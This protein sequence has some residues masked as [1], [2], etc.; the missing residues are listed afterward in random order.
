MAAGLLLLMLGMAGLSGRTAWTCTS[1]CRIAIVSALLYAT[2]L[3]LGAV[4]LVRTGAQLLG[5]EEN[6][7]RLLV[8]NMTDVIIRCGN[9]GSVAFASP[10]AETLFGIPIN[11]LLAHGLFERVHVAD[12]PAFLTTLADAAS[13]GDGRS[14][15]FR[16]QR[17]VGVRRPGQFVWIEMQCRPLDCALTGH[18]KADQN[19]VAVLRDISERKAQEHALETGPLDRARERSQKPRDRHH[20][21]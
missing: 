8:R 5:A 15:E 19:V 6:R 1:S 10:T 13:S 17:D 4:S 9:S 2:G 18:D 16:I 20:R 12:R 21:S 11:R 14:L 3:A 7:Y